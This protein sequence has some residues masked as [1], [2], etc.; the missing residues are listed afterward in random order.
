MA[1]RYTGP[2]Q[3]T[4]RALSVWQDER[5]RGPLLDTT[6]RV[7]AALFTPDVARSERRTSACLILGGL[8]LTV[9]SLFA[10][11]SIFG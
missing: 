5:S 3:W 4:P 11:W 10:I 2:D 6:R 7:R 8:P 9:F 1:P